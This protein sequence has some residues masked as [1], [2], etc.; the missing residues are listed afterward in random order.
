MT[1]VIFNPCCVERPWIRLASSY[2]FLIKNV[3]IFRA[4]ACLAILQRS[5]FNMRGQSASLSDWTVMMFMW[6]GQPRS[7]REINDKFIHVCIPFPAQQRCPCCVCVCGCLIFAIIH[8]KQRPATVA[9]S[10][11]PYRKRWGSWE[12]PS[13]AK[14]HHDSLWL[15]IWQSALVVYQ[16]SYY[17]SRAGFLSSFKLV[18]M[19]E[20][21]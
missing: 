14:C 7:L 21:D 1:C 10:L 20:S 2:R 13:T 4:V 11:A 15:D 3:V 5:V 18:D 19:L 16:E 6:R 8:I 9:G 17:N 12:C